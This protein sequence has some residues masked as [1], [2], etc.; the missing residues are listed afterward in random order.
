MAR[1]QVRPPF[2]FDYKNPNG[3]RQWVESL[4]L[5]WMGCEDSGPD[6][7]FVIDVAEKLNNNVKNSIQDSPVFSELKYEFDETKIS[8]R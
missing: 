6:E 1:F 8:R 2:P 4:G 3:P 5:T 7:P